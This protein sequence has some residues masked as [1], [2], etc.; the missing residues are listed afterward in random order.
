MTN[1][2]KAMREAFEAWLRDEHN[3]TMPELAYKFNPAL[4]E[5]FQAAYNHTD[6]SLIDENQRLRELLRQAHFFVGC[7]AG[8]DSA[9]R[10]IDELKQD[11]EQALSAKGK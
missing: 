5:G 8:N 9:Q 3:V 1:K 6:N 2:D 7:K 4:W 10:G 11:I